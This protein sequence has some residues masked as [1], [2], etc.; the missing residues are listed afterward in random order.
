MHE[1]LIS[2]PQA[3]RNHSAEPSDEFL[4][5][6]YEKH[7]YVLMRFAARLLGGDW[8]RAED[9]FQEAAIRAWQHASE[10]DPSAEALRPWL[11]AVVR[12]L[13][14]D[15]YRVRQARPPEADD[16]SLRRLPVPDGV[17]RALTTQVV[18]DAMRDL[19]PFQREVLLH[20]Y[21]MGRSVSQTAKVLG[22]P[23]GT[24]KSR[25]HY[26]MRALR[27][28]LSSRGLHAA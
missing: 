7:G 4:R 17:D 19:A 3:A 13:V 27:E 28:G 1:L 9:A 5:A 16:E 18:V 26:A 2:S 21:Y 24:V 20:M 11:F 10:L 14:I 8:H 15:G 12:D 6:L 25:T 22:V 23:P